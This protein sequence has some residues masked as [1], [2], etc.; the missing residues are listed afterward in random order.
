[1]AGCTLVSRMREENNIGIFEYQN[2][3]GDEQ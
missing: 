2:R 3:D 1:M